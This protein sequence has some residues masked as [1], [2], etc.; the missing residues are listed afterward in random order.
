MLKLADKRKILT[1]IVTIILVAASCHVYAQ[2]LPVGIV[3]TQ[4]TVKFLQMGLISSVAED[5]G[6][7]L[8]LSG[9]SNTS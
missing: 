8:Q 4:D 3:S 1:I 2:N 5:G 6:R 9:V 7:G